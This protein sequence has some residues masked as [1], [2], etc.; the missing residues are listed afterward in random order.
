M[1]SVSHTCVATISAIVHAG[2]DPVLVEVR[3]DFTMDMS[4]IEQAITPRTRAIVPVH[5]NG[6]SCDM[7]RLMDMLGAMI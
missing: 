6:R 4:E 2:A 3:A 7:R 5:L 1:I